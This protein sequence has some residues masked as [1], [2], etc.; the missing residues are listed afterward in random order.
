M[1]AHTEAADTVAAL[2]AAWN[3]GDLARFTSFLTEDVYWHDLGMLHPPV[4]GREAVRAFSD[5]V[6][7]AF[8]DFHFELR[9]SICVAADGSCCVVPWTISATNSGPYD[10]PGFAPTGRPLRFDGMDFIE[11]RDG[12]VARIETRFDLIDVMEQM[13]GM[14][15]RPVAGSWW[16]KI[17]IGVQRLMA[18][19]ARRRSSQSAAAV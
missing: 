19:W 13:L 9:R 12:L 2:L 5:T 3:A 17:L 1:D 4:V 6:L 8:P 10:P 7:R 15:L 14:S 16:E 11:F 18:A